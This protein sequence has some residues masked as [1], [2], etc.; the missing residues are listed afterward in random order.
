MVYFRTLFLYL[1]PYLGIGDQVLL[2]KMGD[3]FHI[4]H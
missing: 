2:I 3:V 1:Q 4:A